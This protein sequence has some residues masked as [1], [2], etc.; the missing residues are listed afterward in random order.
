MWHLQWITSKIWISNSVIVVTPFGKWKIRLDSK[1]SSYSFEGLSISYRHHYEWLYQ[2]PHFVEYPKSTLYRHA[3][4][5]LYSKDIDGKKSNRGP[6]KT[7]QRDKRLTK[8]QIRL[9]RLAIGSFSSKQL[10]R[11]CRL[12][13]MSNSTFRRELKKISWSRRSFNRRL[14]QICCI[15]SSSTQSSVKASSAGT[16]VN[17]SQTMCTVNPMKQTTGSSFVWPE[18]ST[19]VDVQCADIIRTQK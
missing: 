10:H 17:V 11:S 1:T 6:L 19:H 9:M 8:R 16:I 18:I 3:K 5:S 14:C 4:K 15:K 7:S 2:I 13:N 12:N